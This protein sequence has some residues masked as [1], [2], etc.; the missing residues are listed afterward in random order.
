MCIYIYTRMHKV[1][2]QTYA[3][4]CIR[5]SISIHAASWGSFG[6]GRGICAR[7]PAEPVPRSRSS[8]AAEPLLLQLPQGLNGPDRSMVHVP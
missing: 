3:R 8:R 5:M 2:S 7:L 6:H 1:H 4:I